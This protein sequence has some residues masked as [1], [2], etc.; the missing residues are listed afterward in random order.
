MP[1]Q[2]KHIFFTQESLENLATN[3]KNVYPQFGKEKFFNLVSDEEWE[4]REL[5]EKMYHTT[6]CLHA[7]LPDS[8]AEALSILEQVAPRIEGFEALCLPDFVD[9]YGMDDWDLS[10]P[11]LGYF[12]RYSTSEFAIRPFLAQDPERVMPFMLQWAEEENENLRRFASEGCRPRLPWAMALPAFKK[13]PSPI[14]PVIEK[15]KNDDS[16]YVRKSVANNL[17]DISKDHPNLVLDISERWYGENDNTDWV[18]KHGC[19]TLLK[20]GNPRALLLFGFCDPVNIHIDNLQLGVEKLAIGEVLQF[21]FILKNDTVEHAKVRLEYTVDFQ[22]ASGK[23][24]KKVFQISERV[25]PP[26]RHTIT[27]KHS[28]K[29]MSTRK[30]HPGQHLIGIVVNGEEKGRVSLVL[31]G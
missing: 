12:S 27:K 7:T 5:K 28:F 29:N 22:K 21:S 17:N 2:L 31:T 1:E 13:D 11:A 6:R 3:I 24:S 25:Y 16:E 19:R 18:V 30:H 26:G 4:A 10:L 23:R 14:L 15:L 20:A 9:Q 8:Y